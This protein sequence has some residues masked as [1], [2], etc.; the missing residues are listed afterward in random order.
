MGSEDRSYPDFFTGN[1]GIITQQYPLLAEELAKESATRTESPFKEEELVVEAAASGAPT[2]ICRGISVHSKR[3]PEREAER[4]VESIVNPAHDTANPPI[5]ILG[6]GL[7]YTSSALALALPARPIIIVEKHPEILLAALHAR[8]LRSFLSQNQLVFVLGGSG[9]GVTGALSLFHSSPGVFPLV[10]QNRALTGID[11]EWYGAVE[12]RIKLWNSRSN[13]NRATQKRFAKRWVRNLSQNLS[14]V[15]DIPGISGLFGLVRG[16]GIPVFL[17]AAG[18]MLDACA[19]M[20]GEIAK[21]CLTITVDTSLRF[22]LDHGVNPD[23]ALSVDPQYW[24]FRHLD[25]VPA[26]RTCLVA[27]S[28]VYPPVLR[29]SFRRK[30]LSGSLFP[31]GRFV[32]TKVDPKGDLAAGGSVATSAWDF[33]RVLGTDEIWIAGLD[34]SFPDLK[35]HFK[36]AAFE[37][38]AHSTSQRLNPAETGNFR[39]LRDGHPFYATCRGR[40]TVLTDKRLSLYA[41][42]FENTFAR[43]PQIKTYSLDTAGLAI[44]GLECAD[45]DQLLQLPERRNEIDAFLNEAYKAIESSFYSENEVQRRLETY[46]N[47]SRELLSGLHRIKT[48]AEEMAEIA[49]TALRRGKQGNR[50]ATHEERV[51]KQLDAAGKA[52]AESTVKEIAGFLFPETGEWEEEIAALKLSPFLNHLEFSSRFYRAL[53]SAAQYN[54]QVLGSQQTHGKDFPRQN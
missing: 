22:L 43:F 33:A 7:G 10:M 39:A 54:A 6:F 44:S 1:M 17:A 45:V 32:E 40:G 27:E 38:Q 42:W 21:R 47:T 37:E 18:P 34:L 25:R 52:I 20:L 24:N 13:V 2:L 53:A 31:L 4:L 36:G 49:E 46:E 30:L 9:E 35:T 50:N 16:T 19:P 28:A 51:L 3:D 5:L 26:P 29:H 12:E 11:A 15:R 8:D 41:A 14:A 48:L 23:F